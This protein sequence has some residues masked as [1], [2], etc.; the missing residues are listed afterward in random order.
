MTPAGKIFVGLMATVVLAAAAHTLARAPLLSDLGR[1]SAR[2]MAANGVKDGRANWVSDNGW[3]Y[4]VARISGT[5]DAATRVRTLAA[6][7]AL[8]G[9]HDAVWVETTGAAPAR[10]NPV[11]CDRRIAAILAQRPVQFFDDG[12][13]FAP[14][15]GAIID[16][17]AAAV[18]TCPAARIQI[19]GHAAPA[20]NPLFG[21]ALSQARAEAVVDALIE[22]GIDMRSLEPI[23][24]GT[25]QNETQGRIEVRVR[26]IT[27]AGT[28]AETRS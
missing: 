9:V 7:T 12:S 11:G 3:T 24:L 22:R 26:E 1:R 8:P 16:A 5:A 14:G 27:A 28:L 20:E 21:L 18:R 6:I 10:G 23:G 19:I 4:R 15:A 2:A 25:T 17:L 13:D